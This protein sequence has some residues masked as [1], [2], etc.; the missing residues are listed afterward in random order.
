MLQMRLSCHGLIGPSAKVTSEKSRKWQTDVKTCNFLYAVNNG[1]RKKETI[2][3][4]LL[5]ENQWMEA[6]RKHILMGQ[7]YH[8][9]DAISSFSIKVFVKA[10]H[11]KNTG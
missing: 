4:L 11:H 2:G 8:L 10:L 9:S 5:K 3:T 7:V 1:K 6:G